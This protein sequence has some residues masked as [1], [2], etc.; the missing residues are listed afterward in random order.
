MSVVDHNRAVTLCT[1]TIA[2]IS[3]R[4]AAAPCDSPAQR[5]KLVELL[6]V[7]ADEILTLKIQI[8]EN[9]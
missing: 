4:A 5:R 9:S 1:D 6:D 3:V 7:I 8:G 2:K